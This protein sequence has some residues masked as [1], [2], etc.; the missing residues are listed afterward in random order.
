MLSGLLIC[1]QIL[2]PYMR[3]N[4]YLSYHFNSLY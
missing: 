3:S 1:N 2:L 4:N